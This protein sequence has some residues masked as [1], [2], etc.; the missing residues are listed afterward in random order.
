MDK[1]DGAFFLNFG[2]TI[3]IGL[4]LIFLLGPAV[5]DN[6]N[7]IDKLQDRT[8]AI[9]AC[10]DNPAYAGTTAEDNRQLFLQCIVDYKEANK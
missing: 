5:D 8:D 1:T 7:Q 6:T 10:I 9:V 3:V 2:L 4:I